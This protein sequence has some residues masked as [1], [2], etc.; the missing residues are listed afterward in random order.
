MCITPSCSAH[1][2]TSHS[3]PFLPGP[4]GHPCLLRCLQSNLS[5]FAMTE[6]FKRRS[7]WHPLVSSSPRLAGLS[8]LPLPYPGLPPYIFCVPIVEI[9]NICD[10][11]SPSLF[12]PFQSPLPVF[13]ELPV[14]F[15]CCRNYRRRSFTRPAHESAV[16]LLAVTSPGSPWLALHFAKSNSDAGMCAE[17][18]GTFVP[19]QNRHFNLAF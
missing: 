11:L 5:Q 17:S 2:N 7:V 15:V 6:Y 13:L 1:S 18:V 12:C 3:W 14:G 19:T 9:I 4:A 16:N 8:H 10:I